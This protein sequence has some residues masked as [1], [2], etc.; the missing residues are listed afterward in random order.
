MVRAKEGGRTLFESTFFRTWWKCTLHK[1]IFCIV[2]LLLFDIFIVN[3]NGIFG[4][5]SGRA[6]LPKTDKVTPFSPT[7]T[8]YS[9]KQKEKERAPFPLK[10]WT[11]RM[12]RQRERPLS[13]KKKKN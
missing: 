11:Q 4:K 2:H 1:Y 8:K 9:S 10:K 5:V 12:K 7:Y 3:L 6:P 13:K